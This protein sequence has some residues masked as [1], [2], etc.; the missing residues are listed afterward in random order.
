MS[1]GTA[2]AALFRRTTTAG[3]KPG[4][5]QAP[6]D[7]PCK[8]LGFPPDLLDQLAKGVAA[9]S[10]RT[11]KQVSAQPYQR[12]LTDSKLWQQFIRLVRGQGFPRQP[13]IHVGGMLV[14]GE[15]PVDII[16]LAQRRFQRAEDISQQGLCAG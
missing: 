10:T 7:D 16:P 8:A 6:D 4:Q 11:W 3:L 14:T 9:G 15:P 1:P 12:M 5:L 13:G 2:A